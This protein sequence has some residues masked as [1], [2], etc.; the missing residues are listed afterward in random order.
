M[1]AP[2]ITH[3]HATPAPRLGLVLSRGEAGRRGRQERQAG[4]AGRRGRQER[5]AGE[6]GRRGR[7]ERQAG[8]C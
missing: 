6:A 1:Q 7:Q 5:Q 4:E 8:E 2:C 3:G